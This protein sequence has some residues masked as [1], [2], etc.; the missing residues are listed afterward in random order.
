MNKKKNALKLAPMLVWLFV[1]AVIPILY[2]VVLS[3]LT[4]GEY[5]DIVFEFTLNNYKRIFETVYLKI[6]K[7]SLITAFLTSLIALAVGYPFAY[8]TV[9]LKKKY[10]IFVMLFIML[11]F[12]SNSLLRIFGWIIM[13]KYDGVVNLFFVHIGIFKEPMRMLYNEAVV[14]AGMVYMLLPFMILPLYNSIDKLDLQ[15]VEA[16]R[17]LG[18]GRLK[19][20]LTV[21]LP[22]TV[23]GII[24]GF[25]L[26]FIPAA[27]L[28][29]ISDLLGGAKGMLIGNLIYEQMLSVRDWPFGSAVSVILL[30]LVLCVIFIY[31]RFGEE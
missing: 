20:F 13:L 2:I 29:F 24:G 9:R 7:K 25:T 8:F 11:P 30:I 22:L 12:L 17:D 5:G 1:F 6:L 18:A 4:R 27:G 23:R 21:T 26:V 19:A 3:F 15:L 28:F 14:L 16:A 31:R 10:K